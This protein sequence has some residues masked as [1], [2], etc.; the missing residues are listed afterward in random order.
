MNIST[1]T[2]F[3]FNS[4]HKKKKY[5][6]I[7][8][9]PREKTIDYVL[10]KY[11]PVLS[12]IKNCK[13]YMATLSP[14]I[15]PSIDGVGFSIYCNPIEYITKFAEENNIKIA[16]NLG[17][18]ELD[19]SVEELAPILKRLNILSLNTQEATKIAKIE[20]KYTKEKSPINSDIKQ[21]LCTFKEYVKEVVAITVGKKGAYAY[22]GKYFY[23]A[24]TF[25]SKRV[26]S[27]GAGDAFEITFSTYY[28][29]HDKDIERALKAVSINSA[30]VVMD[31][32][33]QK[34]L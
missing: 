1:I 12:E 27:L 7:L 33:A 6:K 24:P 22:D 34:G 28:I 3:S 16:H 17:G 10:D 5:I 18:K 4:R 30:S 23:F 21:I 2:N 13:K 29:T 25:P 8:L 9:L 19:F 26:S 32:I 20:Q 14:T 31:F 11:A 15:F